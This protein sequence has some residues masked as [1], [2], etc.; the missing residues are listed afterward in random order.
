MKK[1][2]AL[3]P[4]DSPN[5]SLCAV[6]S[7]ANMDFDRLR[8][9]AERARLGE[10]HEVLL[11][12]IVPDKPKVFY[13]MM[14]CILPR[15]VTEF[16]YRFADSAQASIFMSI[17]VQDRDKEIPQILSCFKRKGFEGEDISENEFAKSHARYLIGGRM[18]SG[19]VEEERVYRFGGFRTS[20]SS[21]IAGWVLTGYALEF[22]ERPG[23]L[24]KFLE[25]LRPEF[26]ISLF[27]Y[28]NY[29]GGLPPPLSFSLIHMLKPH[30]P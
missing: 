18:A 25:F 16:S 29:G 23:A 19:C 30:P 26:N 1:Y 2:A 4:P 13:T 6:L 22:P 14:Q 21:V 24:S 9:V 3:S 11:S 8:F 20:P 7:G 27:H 15:Q 28:R 5:D 10:G 12:V 17:L